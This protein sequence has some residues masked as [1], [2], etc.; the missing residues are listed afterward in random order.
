MPQR[1]VAYL[2]YAQSSEVVAKRQ[3]LL[4][5]IE[6]PFFDNLELSFA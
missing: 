5:L 3:G 6:R 2:R 1:V 4:E